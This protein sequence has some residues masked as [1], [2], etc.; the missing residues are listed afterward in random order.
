MYVTLLYHLVDRMINARVSVPEERFEAQ[1]D[2]L[3][4]QCSI[5]SL[6]DAARIASGEQVAPERSVFI[7]FDDG[8]VSQIH[9]ALPRLRSHDMT[10][11]LFVASRY[12]GRSNRWNP[13]A[14][15]DTRHCTW[16]E[17]DTWLGAGCE[18]GGHTH[19]HIC[20]TRL[21]ESE[22]REEISTNKRVLED[23]FGIKL[24]AF[25]YP[26]GEF[27]TLVE[28]IVA[29]YYEIA[30][31]TDDGGWPFRDSIHTIG[32]LEV[33]SAWS[34]DEFSNQLETLFG[35]IPKDCEEN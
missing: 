30:F 17:L 1:L 24:R 6:S 35:R 27:N 11:A 14:C 4:N 16:K 23:H 25:S 20:L 33:D 8:Y 12:I 26:Y 10:A 13:R 29:E 19:S 9:A 7:T 32:R 31:S 28:H 5:L 21:K 18:I 3:R 15:Y 2:F 34:I 22:I